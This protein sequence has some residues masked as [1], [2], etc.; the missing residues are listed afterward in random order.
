MSKSACKNS[1]RELVE[2]ENM[3]VGTYPGLHCY[4]VVTV[5]TGNTPFFKEKEMVVEGG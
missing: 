3:Y 5:G 4:S 2:A 1:I